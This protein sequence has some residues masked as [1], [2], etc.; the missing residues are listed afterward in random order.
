LPGVVL[1]PL[2][3]AEASGGLFSPDS[4]LVDEILPS[5]NHGERRSFV[6][7]NCIVLHYTGMPTA[8][9]AI[10]LLRNPAA[11]VSSHY[12]VE[13]S[14]RVVQLVP[15]SR[16]AWHAGVSCWRGERDMNSASVGI[17]ICNAGHDGGLPD[18]PER[19]IGA[20]TSLCRDIA[21]RCDVRPE[22]ILAHSDIAPGRKRDPGEKFP[23][24]AL[25]AAGVG[26]W[27]EPPPPS[28]QILLARGHEGPPVRSLQAM[29]SL[30]G[31]DLDASGVFDARTEAV[32]AAFQR[33]FRPERVD[34]AADVGTVETLKLLQSGLRA[35]P[36]E[37]VLAG[38]R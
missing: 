27:I 17:E 6:R 13:E 12:V 4:A 31:Y 34:G 3:D 16:R 18:F 38:S 10:A 11:E 33:H 1:T 7:P 36:D 32:V 22:R 15:E 21:S 28:A 37:F 35:S 20:V 8:A 30:Y 23:W 29:L 26:H 9:A 2:A 19:Q 24:C 5:P 25:A 14:G